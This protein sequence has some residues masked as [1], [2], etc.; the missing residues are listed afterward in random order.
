MINPALDQAAQIEVTASEPRSDFDVTR[1]IGYYQLVWRRL[2]KHRLAMISAGVLAFLTVASFVGPILLPFSDE[3]NLFQVFQ[4]PSWPHIMGTDELGRDIF[5]RILEGGQ[6]SLRV[7][8]FAALMT[9]LVGGTIGTAAGYFG[10]IVD[11][12]LMR[13]TDAMLTIPQIFLLILIASAFPGG[14]TPTVMILALGFTSWTY[15]A[16]IIRSV[17]L[18]LKEKEFVEA[19][20]AVGSGN[21]R[22]MIRHVLPNALGPILVSATLWVGFSILAEST[23]SYLGL[24]IGPPIA[25]WGSML[26]RAQQYIWEAG[27]YALFPGLM[28]LTTVLCINFIGDGLRDAFDPRSIER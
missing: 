16:R 23:L 3:P 25:S 28:I 1:E 14:T 18:S 6:I 15:T 12:V 22:I 19:A 10:S 11:N 24:G 4:P 26:F 8:V 17:V 13:I 9:I 20:R 27:H 7:G 21:L 5:K 2:R